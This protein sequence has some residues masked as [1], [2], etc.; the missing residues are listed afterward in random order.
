MAKSKETAFISWIKEQIVHFKKALY[1]EAYSCIVCGAEL[2]E[3]DRV[4]SLCDKC[5]AKLPFRTNAVC[6]ICGRYVHQVGTC[7]SCYKNQPTYSHAYAPF[8]YTGPIR[9]MINNYKDNGKR[10][11]ATYI[12]KYLVDYAKAMELNADCI[13]YVPSH[14]KA[15]KRRGFEHNRPT[16]EK[17]S[18]A[19]NITLYEPLKRINQKKDQT[20][21]S[22]EERLANVGDCFIL[23]E[24]FDMAQLKDKKILLL[25]DVMTT[26]A[27]VATCAGLLKHNGAKEIIV[28]TLARS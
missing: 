16:S 14:P 25:D 19:L 21:L 3:E 10:W 18:G 23:D 28:L 27:T 24:T 7:L 5:R 8:D 9:T 4:D 11:L 15:I 1:P 2:G 26:G 6:P 13:V 17:V 20:G 12:A 22:F